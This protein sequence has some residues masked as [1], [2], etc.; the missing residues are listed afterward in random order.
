MNKTCNICVFSCH[1]G[2]QTSPS[3]SQQERPR[4]QTSACSQS[5]EQPRTGPEVRAGCWAPAAQAISGFA[6]GWVSASELLAAARPKVFAG[7]NH[8]LC[9][10]ARGLL[11]LRRGFARQVV[12]DPPLRSAGFAGAAWAHRSIQKSSDLLVFQVSCNI[13]PF[14][15]GFDKGGKI[16]G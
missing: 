7:T 3:A 13:C 11:W 15:L 2:E 9:I 8:P 10:L 12:P 14:S 5:W 1:F 6:T 4:Q 16:Q